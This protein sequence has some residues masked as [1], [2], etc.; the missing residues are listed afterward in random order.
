MSFSFKYLNQELMTSGDLGN[1][2]SGAEGSTTLVPAGSG[3]PIFYFTFWKRDFKRS[4]LSPS[5]CSQMRVCVC[6]LL[7]WRTMVLPTLSSI[8]GSYTAYFFLAHLSVIELIYL[9]FL[10]A[11]RA[12]TFADLV[13]TP[14]GCETWE[15]SQGYECCSDTLV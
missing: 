15:G 3:T 11:S 10:T 1:A 2:L 9:F 12:F 14:S 5:P 8:N 6:S 7:G 13:F 4:G